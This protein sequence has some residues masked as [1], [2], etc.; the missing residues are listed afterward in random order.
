MNQNDIQEKLD[1]LEQA[2]QE[3]QQL[4]QTVQEGRNELA[5]G[6]GVEEVVVPNVPQGIA[7]KTVAS[8]VISV[9]VFLN[10][11]FSFVAP[12]LKIDVGDD[13]IYTASSI[14]AV[15]INIGYAMWKDHD[16]TKKSRLRKEVA[17]QVI[18]KK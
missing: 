3:M 11:I 12:H 7:P 6:D 18:P 10:L 5:S 1:K 15:G 2:V 9:I 14:I 4:N 13:L 16:I 17:E 8:I